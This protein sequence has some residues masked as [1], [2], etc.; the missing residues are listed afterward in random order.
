MNCRS[1]GVGS[2]LPEAEGRVKWLCL[3]KW[4]DQVER[5]SVPG[6]I[7]VV[8]SASLAVRRDTVVHNYKPAREKGVL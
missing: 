6:V 5:L 7:F 4:G 1:W 8:G 3:W 2:S